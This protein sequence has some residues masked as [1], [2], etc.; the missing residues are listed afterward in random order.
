MQPPFYSQIEPVLISNVLFQRPKRGQKKDDVPPDKQAKRRKAIQE[1]S[2]EAQVAFID[3]LRDIHPASVVLSAIEKQEQPSIPSVVRKLPSSLLSLRSS[4]YSNMSPHEL[5]GACQRVFDS[6][7]VS[8]EEAT[9]LEESTRLQSHSPLWFHHRTGRITA[10]MFKRVKQ[11]SILKPPTSL[12]K[13]IMQETKVDSSKVPALHWGISNEAQARREYLDS[14]KEHHS[15]LECSESGLHVNPR[16]PHLGATPDGV[17][18]C[19]CCGNGLIEIKCPYK[20]RDK[21]PHDVSDPSFYIQKDENEEF[22]LH[23]DHGYYYQV[24]GQLAV[25]SMDYCDFVCWTPCGMHSE[26]ILSD[27]GFFRDLKPALDKFFISVL[28]PQLLTGSSSKSVTEQTTP[29]T[30]CWCNGKDEGSMV[31]CDNAL[32]R[33]EWFHFQCVGLTRKP[34]G[35]WFCSDNCR[36]E[37]MSTNST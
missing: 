3:R 31:A 35:K 29:N 1:Q 13:M 27:P 5:L 9:Y 6:L 26:R 10:S 16:F 24:Q 2:S 33:R 22:H 36:K 34:R 32:C 20:H 21:H 11:A 8:I 14:A 37:D 17:L 12:I 19:D 15:N 25:C 23:S 28:L 30:Y 18:M 7:S 4:K